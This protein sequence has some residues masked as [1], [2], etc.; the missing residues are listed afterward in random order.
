VGRPTELHVFSQAFIFKHS[1]APNAA[2]EYLRF[3]LSPDQAGAWIDGM[4]GYVTPALKQYRDLPVWTRDPKATPFRDCLARMLP[5]GYAGL[6][7][8]QAAAALAEFIV[9]DMFSD[10]TVNGMSA[11]DAASRAANR[12]RRI[13]RG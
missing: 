13:Y 1:R 5:N 11:K 12:L 8:Q 7:G 6:P 10:V 3:M 4:N 2:K 9:V